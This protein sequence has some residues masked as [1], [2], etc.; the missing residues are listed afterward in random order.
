MRGAMPSGCSVS[1]SALI[2]G[3]S[4]CGAAPAV[5]IGIAALAATT[6]HP[7][8][9]TIAGNGSW[10]VSSWSSASLIGP[11]SSSGRCE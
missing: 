3:S 9:T 1:R 5:S 4:R 10:L 2:G 8:S 6:F 7:R 11:S